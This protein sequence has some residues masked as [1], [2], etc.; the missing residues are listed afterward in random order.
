MDYVVILKSDGTEEKM[1]VVS[2]FDKSDSQ[3]HYIIYK[4]KLGEYYAGKYLQDDISDLSVDFD[5]IEWEYVN[6]IFQFLT[7]EKNGIKA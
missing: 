2:I 4:S 3:Y 6:G 1:E 7:G 5:P